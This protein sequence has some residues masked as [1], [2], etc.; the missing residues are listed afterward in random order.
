MA[1]S[2]WPPDAV[3]LLGQPVRKVLIA[4]RG[5]IALRIL[6]ACRDLNIPAVVAYSDADRDSLPVRLAD[7]AVCIGPATVSRSYTNIPAIISAA[8]VT[9]CDALHPGYGFLSENAYLADVCTKV[10][11]TFI[12]PPADVIAKMGN[13]AEARRLMKEAGVPLMPG[14]DGIVR[15]LAEAKASANK[16]GYPVL[17]KAAAGGGGRGMRVANSESELIRQLPMAQTEAES[18]FG[19]GDVYIE[20]YLD[21][22][23]HVEVQVLADAH[24][25]VYAIGDRDCSLQRRHQKIIE[26][27][28]APFLAKRIRDNI[29]KAAAKGAKAAGYRSAGTLEFLVDSEGRFYFMEMNTRI[30]V[31]HPITEMVSSIDLVTWQLRIAMGEQL[32]LEERD[33]EARGH[34]IECRITAEDPARDFAPSVGTVSTYVA[35]GGPG[36]RVDSH[37]FSGYQVPPFYDSLLA[38]VAVWGKDRAEAIERMERAL[39]ETIIDGVINVA[40]LHRM[41]MMDEPFRKGEIHTGYVADFLKRSFDLVADAQQDDIGP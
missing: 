11:I 36:V 16:V 18:A 13:K 37:L 26:E 20:R 38:K 39:R 12:G 1:A 30:Q 7:E 8:L 23:R 22:P 14:S 33:F 25:H 40:P 29:L 28:P 17:I 4:N 34:A 41:I 19:N 24:G 32:R 21:K 2:S 3:S 31:E 6:R 5:E 35:P 27:A 15:N 10:G 9:G